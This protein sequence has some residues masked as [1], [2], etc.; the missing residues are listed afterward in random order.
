MERV[1]ERTFPLYERQRRTLGM[2]GDEPPA[3]PSQ[4]LALGEPLLAAARRLPAAI[5][6]MLAAPGGEPFDSPSHVFEVKWDG[7][8]ALAFLEDG[9]VRLQDRYLRDVTFQYP[10]MQDLASAVRE[11]GVVLDGE[12]VALDGEGRPQIA[13][14]QERLLAEDA[15]GERRA[16]GRWPA[17]Y[18]AFDLLYCDG[19]SLLNHPLWRRKKLL[20]E[21]VKPEAV[22]RVPDYV[23][24]EGMAFF[25]AV[26]E[27]ELEGV[28]AKERDSLYRPGER[29]R[30]WLKLKVFQKEEFVIGGYTFGGRVGM[31]GA[32][33][34]EPIASLLLGAYDGEGRLAYLGEVSGG[35]TEEAAGRAAAALDALQSPECPFA[36]GPVLPRLIFW[37]RP[38]LACSVRFGGWRSGR[39]QFPVFEGLRPDVPA[40]ACTLDDLAAE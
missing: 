11:R 20:R 14:L 23:T 36:E 40:R 32:R 39:L 16:A 35:F 21:V 31:G 19:R 26:Q 12:I 1:A 7:V 5:P 33:R 37:C 2:S 18:Q 27:H 6:P 13:L 3:G 34:R 4:P 28:I 30:A 38:E 8:R 25:A 17:V 22:L 29:S 10:E 15:E 9:T 24:A